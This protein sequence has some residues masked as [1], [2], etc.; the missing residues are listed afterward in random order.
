MKP[1]SLCYWSWNFTQ[2]S[3]NYTMIEFDPNSE[4]LIKIQ[5][6][7]QINSKL[8]ENFE[9]FVNKATKINI[10][11]TFIRISALSSNNSQSLIIAWNQKYSNVWT[12]TVVL[13]TSFGIAFFLLVL[14]AVACILKKNKQ[15]QV[16]PVQ[17]YRYVSSELSVGS[18]I[19]TILPLALYDKV[20]SI[21]P[22]S[23]CFE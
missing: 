18:I 23:I 15:N 2:Y 16:V 14:C 13:L 1:Y 8:L 11:G 4:F 21:N 6:F 9:I 10:T 20:K 22:C 17:A 19:D 5:S 7:D 12:L 3:Q